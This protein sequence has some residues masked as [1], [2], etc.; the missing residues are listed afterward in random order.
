MKAS[1]SNVCIYCCSD[2]HLI[3][4]NQFGDTFDLVPSN[5]LIIAADCWKTIILLLLEI[6]QM[7]TELVFILLCFLYV[8]KIYV[9]QILINSIQH[10]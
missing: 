7:E 9:I 4:F 3:R 1:F 8:I 10:E 5:S 6:K 2:D